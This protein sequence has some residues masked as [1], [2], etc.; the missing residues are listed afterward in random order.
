MKLPLPIRTD[1]LLLRYHEARDREAFV[2]L[3]TAPSFYEHLNVPERQRTREGAAE[4]FDLV[5][6]SYDTEEPVFGLTIAE[7]DTD[8]FIGT[9]A[10]AVVPERRGERLAVEAVRAVMQALP[11]RGFVARAPLTNEASKRVALAVGMVDDGIE[12]P[13]GGP[14]RHRFVRPAG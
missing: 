14:E 10:L 12:R 2:Q 5:L 9:V 13:L 8:T 4:V 1:R 7:R 6:S 11:D 3:V